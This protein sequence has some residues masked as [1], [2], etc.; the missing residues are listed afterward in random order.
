[1]ESDATGTV[2]LD[3]RMQPV[4]AFT[5]RI[6]GFFEAVEALR[7]RGLIRGR[8]ASMA[9]LV[10]GAM[11][12]PAPGGGPPVLSLPVTLQDRVLY[13]GPVALVRLPEL[14]WPGQPPTPAGAP[15]DDRAGAANTGV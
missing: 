11:A 1:V 2:A 14:R 8:D 12:R 10:L 9:K 5:A 3:G 13:A 7:A 15:G 4:G 6:Q